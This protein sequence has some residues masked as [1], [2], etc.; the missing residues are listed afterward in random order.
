MH[1]SHYLP[2]YLSCAVNLESNLDLGIVSSDKRKKL[3]SR[4]LVLQQTL[5]AGC[6]V[7]MHVR[8]RKQNH[9]SVEAKY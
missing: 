2:N 3:T 5:Y 8:R 1:S 7:I 6:Y 9:E 4:P